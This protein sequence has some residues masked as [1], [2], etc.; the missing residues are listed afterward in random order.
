MENESLPSILSAIDTLLCLHFASS[1]STPSL[2]QL[3]IKATH[4]TKRRVDQKV[5]EQILGYDSNAYQI[6]YTGPECN[7]YGLFPPSKVTLAK[8][9]ASIPH[10]RKRLEE[11]VKEPRNPTK[12]STLLR[13]NSQEERNPFLSSFKSILGDLKD[14]DSHSNP[15]SSVSSRTDSSRGLFKELNSKEGSS[16]IK[17]SSY[18]DKG[19]I[20]YDADESSELNSP[21][22]SPLRY[23]LRK[24]LLSSASLSPSKKLLDTSNLLPVTPTK[25]IGPNASFDLPESPT[26]PRRSPVKVTKLSDSLSNSAR[27]FTLFQKPVESGGLSLLERIKQKE[28]LRNQERALNTQEAA[29][30][31]RILGK[32]PA[33][34]DVLYELTINTDSL[35]KSF[36]LPKVISMVIDSFALRISRQEVQDAIRELALAIPSRLEILEREVLVLKVHRLDRH[37]DVARIH[38]MIN[39]NNA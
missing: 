13:K 20:F 1:T 37:D 17:S 6:V 21:S 25:K 23:S 14:S 31:K 15:E 16:N 2:H 3:C 24:G 34:Y 28:K 10:R 18:F 26:K 33:L 11:L 19:D 8:F 29:Y 36:S 22:V 5:V 38:A 39:E 32:L 4:L 35:F 9:G 7:D 12:F 27:K 30:R